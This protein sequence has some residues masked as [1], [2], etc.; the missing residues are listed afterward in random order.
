MQTAP[1]EP[2]D[3]ASLAES[4]AQVSSVGTSVSP[5]GKCIAHAH[6]RSSPH[7]RPRTPGK[8]TVIS[9]GPVRPFITWLRR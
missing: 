8:V 3:Q 5:D 4:W 9:P 2:L 6:P 1:Y 7:S